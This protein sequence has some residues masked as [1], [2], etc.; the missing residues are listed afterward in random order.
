MHAPHG[1]EPDSKPRQAPPLRL[2]FSL[3][4]PC[5][6]IRLV[7][8]YD[9]PFGRDFGSCLNLVKER[10]GLKTEVCVG[11]WLCNYSGELF[12]ALIRALLV[13]AKR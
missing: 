7:L 12:G 10:T 4:P 6:P 8:W 5:T 3:L 13:E 11:G 2:A 9:G 1:A